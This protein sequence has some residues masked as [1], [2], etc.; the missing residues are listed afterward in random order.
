MEPLHR[1]SAKCGAR[2]LK[3]E[4]HTAEPAPKPHNQDD[5]NA[6]RSEVQRRCGRGRLH[7]RQHCIGFRRPSCHR[8]QRERRLRGR[9]KSRRWRRGGQQ[10]QRWRCWRRRRRWW[11]GHWWGQHSTTA[12]TLAPVQLE[13]GAREHSQ[14]VEAGKLSGTDAA[15]VV[16][17]WGQRRWR[18]RW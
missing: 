10:R 14:E 2:A 16:T 13:V 7:L 11:W 3:T 15:W 9:G 17:A 8:G 5:E 6:A 12:S 1:A 18:K 4:K